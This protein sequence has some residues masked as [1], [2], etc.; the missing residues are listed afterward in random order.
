MNELTMTGNS[1]T[2]QDSKY[3]GWIIGHFMPEG[4]CNSTDVEVKLWLYHQ[5]PDYGKKTFHGTELI[6]VTAGCLEIDIE[7][8]EEGGTKPKQRV[9]VRADALLHSY[10]LIPPGCT[11][12]VSVADAPAQGIC[13]RWPSKQG[14]SVI[15]EKVS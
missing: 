13:V 14:Q 15:V 8:P 12:N 7:Y 11:K 5:S 10:V 1:K 4:L 3:Y 2:A 9:S 6:I